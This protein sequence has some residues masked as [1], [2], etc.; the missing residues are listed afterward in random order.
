MKRR[1]QFQKNIVTLSETQLKVE[2]SVV[3][4]AKHSVAAKTSSSHSIAGNGII[5]AKPPRP[6][7]IIIA[8]LK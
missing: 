8:F 7:K 4:N 1:K 5:V 3:S 6:Q 2:M